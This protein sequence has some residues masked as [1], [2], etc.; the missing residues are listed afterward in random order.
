V[1]NIL[2]RQRLQEDYE[3]AFKYDYRPVQS[4]WTRCEKTPV[5]DDHQFLGKDFRK[6]TILTL[7]SGPLMVSIQ[8]F[9]TLKKAESFLKCYI[10][11]AASNSSLIIPVEGSPTVSYEPKDFLDVTI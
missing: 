8:P 9:L 3:N 6:E 1:D 4:I 5:E 11:D 2:F 7:E 10:L